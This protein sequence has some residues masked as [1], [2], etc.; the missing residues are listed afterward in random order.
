[1]PIIVPILVIVVLT[2]GA[3]FGL[4]FLTDIK[5][6]LRNKQPI[7][8]N[9]NEEP[10]LPYGQCRLADCQI[11]GS[12]HGI[13]GISDEHIVAFQ[14]TAQ[15]KGGMTLQQII[16][17][18]SA[19]ARDPLGARP[20]PVHPLRYYLKG[21]LTIPKECAGKNLVFVGTLWD[22]LH[23]GRF[24]QGIGPDRNGNLVEKTFGND[25]PARFNGEFFFA[26]YHPKIVV[27]HGVLTADRPVHS[28]A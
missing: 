3:I 5:E 21:A 25:K 8:I 13:V 27:P 16:D 17:S 15:H 18:C 2:L 12:A 26:F 1:M 20:L 4:G 11:S 10:A 9:L 7:W 22:S 14:F 28:P 6:K 23:E 19:L 24:F